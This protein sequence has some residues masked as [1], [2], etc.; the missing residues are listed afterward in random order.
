MRLHFARRVAIEPWLYG[1]AFEHRRWP[2]LGEGDKIAPCGWVP[3][4]ELHGGEA[5]IERT[6]RGRRVSAG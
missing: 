3:T 6:A 2:T 4:S 5:L 1:I